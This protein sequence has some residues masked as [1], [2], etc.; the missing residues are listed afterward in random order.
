MTLSNTVSNSGD[1]LKSEY[2]VSC[3]S[4]NTYFRHGKVE[5]VNLIELIGL[6]WQPN[7]LWL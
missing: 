1:T 5:V 4:I 2:A 6:S 3:K 7:R